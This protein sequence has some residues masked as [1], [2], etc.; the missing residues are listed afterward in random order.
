MKPEL[1]GE[2]ISGGKQAAEWPIC[3]GERCSRFIYAR[4]TEIAP[5]SGGSIAYGVGLVGNNS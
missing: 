5:A 4:Y 1:L 2:A 3:R